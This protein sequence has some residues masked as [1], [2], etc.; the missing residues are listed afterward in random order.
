MPITPYHFGLNGFAGLL[1]RKWVDVPMALLANVLID[2]EVIADNHFA[3]G[4]PVHQLW[5]FHTLLIGGLAGAVMGSLFYFV[6]PLRRPG[7]MCW[8]TAFIITMCRSSGRIRE[9]RSIHG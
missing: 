6:K 7:C 5:H 9:I 2:I 3:P 1:L 4:W 8:L